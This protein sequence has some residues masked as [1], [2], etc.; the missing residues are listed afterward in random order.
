MEG[1]LTRSSERELLDFSDLYSSEFP[2]VYRAAWLLARDEDA[3]LEATQEAFAKAWARWPKLRKKEWVLGWVITTALN[4]VRDRSRGPG[5]DLEAQTPTD[6]TTPGAKLLDLRAALS[7]LP[8]RRRQ[9][10]VL[11]YITDLTVR[12][13]AEVMDLSEGTVKAH[14]AQGRETLRALLEEPSD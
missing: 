1:V 8:T 4:E 9:A 11:F 10:I 5:T 12:S 14:L 7:K 6:P 3:A 2:R 13:V